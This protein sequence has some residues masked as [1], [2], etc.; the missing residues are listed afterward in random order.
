MIMRTRWNVG[1]LA[2]FGLLLGWTVHASETVAQTPPNKA[3]KPAQPTANK[4]TIQPKTTARTAKPRA[5]IPNNVPDIKKERK[6]DGPGIVFDTPAYNF[7][8]VMSGADI[9][10]EFWFTNPGVEPLTINSVRPSCGCTTAG[11]WDRRVAPGESGR[12]PIRLKTARFGGKIA[13][14][15]TVTTNVPGSDRIT[16]R[17]EGEVWQPI[18]VTPPRI[19]FGRISPSEV[20]EPKTREVII[21]NNTDEPLEITGVDCNSKVYRADVQPVEPGKKFKCTVTALPP[22]PAG[23]MAAQIKLATNFKSKPQIVLTAS[24]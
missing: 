9:Y 10:H 21:T 19:S 18:T 15:V 1:V 20:N 16:L 24:A 6:F 14:T 23:S 11:S 2:G 8:E 12:I 5:K 4:A 13:K 17:I 3:E 7:A 22:F